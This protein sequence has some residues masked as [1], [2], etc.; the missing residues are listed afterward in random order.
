MSLI[1]GY[2]KTINDTPITKALELAYERLTISCDKNGVIANEAMKKANS[3]SYRAR[4]ADE[5]AKEC[6]SV[7]TFT[8][9]IE[10]THYGSPKTL[11]PFR[12]GIVLLG[13]ITNGN[14]NTGDTV[15]Y[16]FY[17]ITGNKHVST[18]QGKQK[19]KILKSSAEDSSNNIQDTYTSLSSCSI[20]ISL[21]GKD[22]KVNK[23]SKPVKLK[24][25]IQY[26]EL[27]SG[28]SEIEK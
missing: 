3:A 5:A 8:G 18:I 23:P 9:E 20:S 19:Y 12:T 13:I 28:V 26:I 15:Q 11:K 10:I 24:I 2:S 16:D 25:T 14:P 7:K 22:I 27:S 6:S 17:D 4:K 21:K 1:Y